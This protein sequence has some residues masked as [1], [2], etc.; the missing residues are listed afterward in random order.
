MQGSPR[1]TATASHGRLGNKGEV[2]GEG[3]MAL[4]HFDFSAIEAMD[5]SIQGGWRICYDRECP[6]ELRYQERASSAQEVGT[7]EAIKVK[8]LLLGPENAPEALKIELSSETD[9]FFHFVHIVDEAGFRVMQEQQ[10]LMVD[11]EEY[12]RVL[13][14]MLNSCI[15]EPNTHLAI[16]VLHQEGK[17]RLDF[18]KNMEYKFVELLTCS[19]TRSSEEL[20]RQH[21]SYRYNAMKSRLALMQARLSDVNALVKSKNP[22]LL[23]QIKRPHGNKERK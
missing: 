8:L 6:L 12:S 21:I 23:L 17:S 2:A 16:F 7:L 5:P 18:I 14:R 20:V 22:S 15:K 19:F 3:G 1:S 9:L 4:T 10:K 13:I 11:F